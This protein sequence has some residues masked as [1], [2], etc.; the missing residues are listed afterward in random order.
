MGN[1]CPPCHLQ[2]GESVPTHQV[3]VN[4]VAAAPTP[5]DSRSQT[6]GDSPSQRSATLFHPRESDRR[7]LERASIEF[8]PSRREACVRVVGRLVV[9]SVVGAADRDRRLHDRF[10]TYRQHQLA[11]LGA[12]DED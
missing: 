12:R 3:G 2:G 8:L 1:R 9:G 7:P 5:L 6:A 4:P 11:E 10:Q